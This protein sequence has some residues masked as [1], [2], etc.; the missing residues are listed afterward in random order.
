MAST[1]LPRLLFLALLILPIFCASVSSSRASERRETLADHAKFQEL[2]ADLDDASIHSVLHSWSNKFKDG[3]FSK[4]RTAIEA[5]HSMDPPLATHLVSLARRQ[6]SNTTTTRPPL[7]TSTSQQSSPKSTPKNAPTTTNSE[8]RTSVLP[9]ATTRSGAVAI[10]TSDGAIVFSSSGNGALE[11]LSSSTAL[12][13]FR[14]STTT[15]TITTTLPGGAQSILTSVEVVN[16]A[17][18]TLPTGSVAADSTTTGSA[19]SLQ[20]NLACTA[21]SHMKEAIAVMGAAVL[22]AMAL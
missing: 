5:V 3:V 14:Q 17:A 9:P 15:A 10:S 22:F 8:L 1:Q 7:S 19:P 12:I 18:A 4:D 2:L 16:A 13:S 6:V 11:T 21:K 20:T